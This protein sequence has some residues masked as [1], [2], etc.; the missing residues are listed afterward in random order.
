MRRGQITVFFSLLLP[1]LLALMGTTL[2]SARHQVIRSCIERSLV[3][4]EYSFLSEYQKELWENYGVFFLD[5]GYGTRVESQDRIKRRILGYLRENLLQ[6][7]D[8]GVAGLNLFS[9][10]VS[11]IQVGGFSR[12]TDGRGM[13]FYEQAVAYEKKLWGVDILEAWMKSGEYGRELEEWQDF[14]ETT[15]AQERHNLEVLRARRLEEEEVDT[16]DP[17]AGLRQSGDGLLAMVLSFPEQVSVRTV[18]LDQVPS[19]RRLLNGTEGRYDGNQ[20]KDQWF[21]TYLLEHFANARDVLKE[22]KTDGG[23]LLYETE[24]VLAGK[25]SD[26]ENL[27]EVV[28]RLVMLREGANYVYLLTDE[29]K[30]QEAYALAALVAGIT[31]MPEIVDVLHQV[32]L[33]AWAYG[34]SVL[35]VRGLLQGKR[36][37][38]AKTR[39]SWKLSLGQLFFLKAS[40]SGFDGV[41]DTE[42]LDYEAYLRILATMMGR[43]TKCMRGL[44]VIEGNLRTTEMGSSLFVDQC[45]DGLWM[46]VKLQYPPV[47]SS[48]FGKTETEFQELTAERRVSY[49]W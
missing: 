2:E 44:D 9:V 6:E 10:A 12:M 13:E 1:L 16:Q 36:V 43:E 30:K 42:G 27:K 8:T 46:K 17:T 47:F 15:E 14:Y 41:G 19:K 3:L 7:M 31:L 45:V 21:H 4:C 29:G 33:L 23:W 48:L 22:E 26:Q 11:D 38:L 49:E 24:Y 35:D 25:E 5:T 18:S 34:E 39:E 20:V 40:L 37:A 28:K 32:I